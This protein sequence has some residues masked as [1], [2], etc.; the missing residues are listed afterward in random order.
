MQTTEMK[1]RVPSPLK[2]WLAA[3]AEQ[4]SRSQNGEVLHL[5]KQAMQAEKPTKEKAQ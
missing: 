3:R 4:N 1:I 5:L 2:A